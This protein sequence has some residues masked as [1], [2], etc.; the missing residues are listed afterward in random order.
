MIT[1][2]RIRWEDKISD[3]WVLGSIMKYPSPLAVVEGM[4]QRQSSEE[5]GPAQA[6]LS[7]ERRQAVPEDSSSAGEVKEGSQ[8]CSRGHRRGLLLELQQ[9]VEGVKAKCG[10]DHLEC[11]IQHRLSPHSHKDQGPGRYLERCRIQVSKYVFGGSQNRTHRRG[12][13]V[14]SLTGQ[15]LQAVHEGRMQ[16]KRATEESPGGSGG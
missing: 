2:L 4:K 3:P 9:G 14:V 11:R 16:G 8:E 15:A 10:T 5:T 7:S 1:L 13:V 12:M 6:F